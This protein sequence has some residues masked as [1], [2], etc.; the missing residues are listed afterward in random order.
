MH[1]INVHDVHVM[2]VHLMHVCDACMH[3]C[4]ECHGM[5]VMHIFDACMWCMVCMWSICMVCMWC[6][7]IWCMHVI[8]ACIY[9][10]NVVACM[11]CL[12]VHDIMHT[13]ASYAPSHIYIH[14]RI[15]PREYRQAT[16]AYTKNMNTQ[17]QHIIIGP[18]TYYHL[19]HT[20]SLL[21]FRVAFAFAS[22]LTNASS[23]S[24]LTSSRSFLASSRSSLARSRSF[25]VCEYTHQLDTSMRWLWLKDYIRTVWSLRKCLSVRKGFWQPH[26]CCKSSRQLGHIFLHALLRLS[27]EAGLSSD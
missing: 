2:H 17:T 12:C 10:M 18:S 16:L 14:Q 21:F 3:V 8:H 6:M 19:L 5:H 22:T 11:W 13:H 26:Y 1:V 4:D 24:F 9:V 25:R 20:T 15:L 7:C 23:R 27:H